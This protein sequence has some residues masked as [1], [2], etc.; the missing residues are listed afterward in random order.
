[1]NNA[2]GPAAKRTRHNSWYCPDLARASNEEI[3]NKIIDMGWRRMMDDI[4]TFMA[5]VSNEEHEGISK[6][7]LNEAR[8]TMYKAEWDKF[9]L[10]RDGKV[11]PEILMPADA[12]LD[13]A[14]ENLA[15]IE[16][17]FRRDFQQP[18]SFKQK[19]AKNKLDNV[20]D[21]N[22][23]M[24][25]KNVNKLHVDVVYKV[26]EVLHVIDNAYMKGYAV[27][28]SFIKH[29]MR[30]VERCFEL[31]YA[32][33]QKVM[34][35]DNGTA[36]LRTLFLTKMCDLRDNNDKRPIVYI[37]E[38][39]VNQNLSKNASQIEP[40]TNKHGIEVF[41]RIIVCLAV[42]NKTGIVFK[43]FY[44]PG[45][46]TADYYRQQIDETDFKQW[47]IKLL[48]RLPEPSVIVMDYSPYRSALCKQNVSSTASP[49]DLRTWL[50]QKKI[51]CW[52]EE[53]LM[54]LRHKVEHAHLRIA[55]E[56]ELDRLAACMQHEVVRLP[57]FQPKYSPMQILWHRV[58]DDVFEH[59][60]TGDMDRIC[61]LVNRAIDG[62]SFRE[63]S[64]CMENLEQTF[65]DRLTVN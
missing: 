20:D 65:R 52:P 6:L 58:K 29:T 60:Y 61:R 37:D 55:P 18:L 43:Q 51:P 56:Y 17:N 27:S 39:F 24:I 41:K 19:L 53:S 35:H 46:G 47:F 25:K 30:K 32:D 11:S 13:N 42:S 9:C 8:A 1:M 63:W 44:Q 12:I 16:A 2:P 4:S 3:K 62:I 21:I 31:Y 10:E 23:N 36:R 40:I 5:I 34:D 50:L 38:M 64:R 7:W 14:V 33:L 45:G 22:K 59:N 49:E 54:Q 15:S 48:N 26:R 28:L 57:S